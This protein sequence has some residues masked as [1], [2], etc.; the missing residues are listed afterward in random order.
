VSLFDG[1]TL[2]GWQSAPD[3]RVEE[4]LLVCTGKSMDGNEKDKLLTQKT[5]RDFR[6]RF[7]YRLDRCAN[8]R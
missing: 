6:L 4:G 1:K 3:F 8:E 7:E 2:A 5:Y